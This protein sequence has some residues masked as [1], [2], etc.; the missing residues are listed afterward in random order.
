[1][2]FFLS[3][4][5]A[6]F[7]SPLVRD[8]IGSI[9]GGLWNSLKSNAKLAANDFVS[10][11]TQSAIKTINDRIRPLQG[12]RLNPFDDGTD[13]NDWANADPDPDPEPAFEEPRRRRPLGR[14]RVKR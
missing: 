13:E 14:K 3:A 7:S 2:S 5:P 6:L 4:L 9:A 8:T 12:K 11:T 10:N 1:M